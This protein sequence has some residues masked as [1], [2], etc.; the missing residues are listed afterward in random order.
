MTDGEKEVELFST[1]IVKSLD[2]ARE[3]DIHVE[4]VSV[5]FNGLSG[6]VNAAAYLASKIGV[7]DDDLIAGL[8]LS[9]ELAK[10]KPL[11]FVNE[12]TG[13]RL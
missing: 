6:L 7:D 5:A 1:L 9:L 4:G 3:L 11:V 13:A 2:K 8:R 12:K 10:K